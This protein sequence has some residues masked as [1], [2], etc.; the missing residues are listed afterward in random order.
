MNFKNKKIKIIFNI[1]IYSFACIG[2]VFASVF[3]AMRLHLTNVK[4]SIDTRNEFFNNVNKGVARLPKI[5]KSNISNN[6]FS[7]LSPVTECQIMTISSFLPE[8][9]KIILDNYMATKSAVIAD[10]MVK[11][12]MLVTDENLFMKEKMS[13]CN[14]LANSTQ[15]SI[16]SNNTV[17]DWIMSPEWQTLRD[18]LVKDKDVILQASRDS[19]VPARVIIASVI[20][21]QFRFFSS[22]RESFKRYFEPLKI[23]GNGTKFSYGV[24]GVKFETAKAIE[25]NL[26]DK[27]SSF[28]LGEDHE[29]IFNYTT[30]NPDEELLTRLTNDNNHYYSYMYT[31]IFLKEIM[32]Q[33]KNAGYDISERPEVLATLFNLGFAKSSPKPDP[34]VGGSTITINDRDYTF[35]GL[36]YEFYYS[37]ELSDVFPLEV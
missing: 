23:L 32:N 7:K 26:K 22:N 4:G 3:M 15:S 5:T 1:V 10:K 36:S 37:G 28:Y 2:L 35:G 30:S 31:A 24:A 11:A 27:N 16:I 12:V 21:E 17:F 14:D 33:W 9:G 18:A 8:N 29:D 6:N 19:G 13:K 34:E 20:S 25:A